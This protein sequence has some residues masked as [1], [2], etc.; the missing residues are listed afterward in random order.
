[1]LAWSRC[2]AGVRSYKPAEAKDR[3]PQPREPRGQGLSPLPWRTPSGG[4]RNQE[5]TEFFRGEFIL[6]LKTRERHPPPNPQ[7]FCFTRPATVSSFSALGNPFT[8]TISF[9]PT[10]QT[11]GVL[12]KDL[13]QPL[14]DG[15]TQER[16]HPPSP[17]RRV[18]GLL[19]PVGAVRS[20]C[21]SLHPS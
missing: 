3:G 19:A 20:P 16:P 18:R 5:L 14:W 7:S 17:C 8:S 10:S 11:R 21:C 13:V 12:L 15:N 2:S 9:L 4:H 6:P 1:M